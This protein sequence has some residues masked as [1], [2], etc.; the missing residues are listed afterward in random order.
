MASRESKS[1]GFT[2][3][4]LMV[5]LA[6]IA[7]LAMVAVPSFGSLMRSH[8][9]N[10]VAN[11]LL[12]DL[13]YVRA[14][15]AMRGKYVSIC[16]SDDGN[17]C[18]KSNDY[19]PGW[20][21]YAYPTGAAGANQ[22]YDQ[23]KQDTYVMLRATNAPQGVVITAT[24]AVPLTYGQQ[25]QVKRDLEKSPFDLIVCSRP[26]DSDGAENSA[27]VPGIDVGL[28]GSGGVTLKTLALS[29]SCS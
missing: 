9:V 13:T 22:A 23:T 27:A 17:S 20:I 26:S 1:G 7:I 4:E 21:V 15:A 3:V 6:V 8:R 28:I 10:S 19:A 18:S 11:Q 5:T 14:E 24:D 25:G 29:A 2:L 16:A 12:A